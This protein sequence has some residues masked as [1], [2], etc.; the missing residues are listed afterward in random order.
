MNETEWS[1]DVTETILNKLY[2]V[3]RARLIFWDWWYFTVLQDGQF[4][5][6]LIFLN[7]TLNPLVMLKVYLKAIIVIFF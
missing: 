1:G 4:T 3:V 2:F 6:V 5:L 7:R